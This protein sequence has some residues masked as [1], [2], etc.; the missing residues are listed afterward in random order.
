MEEMLKNIEQKVKEES[1]QAQILYA[2]IKQLGM[3]M[4]FTN[5]INKDLVESFCA[6]MIK[7]YFVLKN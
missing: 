2:E 3:Y 1:E 4:M 5:S 7:L 6:K